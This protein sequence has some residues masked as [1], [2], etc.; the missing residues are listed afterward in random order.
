MLDYF[1]Q[2]DF[3]V[4]VQVGVFLLLLVYLAIHRKDPHHLMS[5]LSLFRTLIL[6]LLFLYLLLNYASEIPPSLRTS[7]LFGMFLINLYMLWNA[8][9]TR[10][11]RPYRLALVACA[12]AP[13]K[14][15]T[16]KSAWQAGKH[17]YSVRYF[18]KALF[19]GGAIRPFLNNLAS[20]QVREDLKNSFQKQGVHQEFISLKTLVS[21]LQKQLAQDDTLPQEFKGSMD[22]AIADFTVHPWIAEQINQFLNL[23][24]ASPEV[25]FYPEWSADQEQGGKTPGPSGG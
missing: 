15:E 25:L 10:L 14:V 3:N 16:L 8:V 21:Y 13:G 12:Q 5:G 24:L 11:E 4:F 23:V 20:H 2:F 19:S 6:I 9:L 22:K 18:L 17:F 1:I 7:S